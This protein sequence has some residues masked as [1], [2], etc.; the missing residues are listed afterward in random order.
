VKGTENQ[1][2]AALLACPSR[3]TPAPPHDGSIQSCRPSCAVFRTVLAGLPRFRSHRQRSDHN[4]FNEGQR[5]VKM[6]FTKQASHSKDDLWAAAG[7]GRLARASPSPSSMTPRLIVN[8]VREQARK[9]PRSDRQG[10]RA[11]NSER[12]NRAVCHMYQGIRIQ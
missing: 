11:L 1:R 6:T 2:P 10:L 9:R 8:R 7:R 5:H 12:E 4:A 3:H